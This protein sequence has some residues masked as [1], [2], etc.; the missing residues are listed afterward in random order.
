MTKLLIAV[1][2]CRRHRNEG[3]HEPIRRTWAQDI[4]NDVGFAFFMGGSS[5][6]CDND[7]IVLSVK[8]DYDALPEKSKAILNW[9]MERKYDYTVLAD[10]DTFIIPKKL[11]ALPFQQYDLAGRFGK[12]KPI[13]ET[14]RYVDGR[15]IVY[16]PCWPWPSGG[17]GYFV[18]A[19]GAK[20]IVETPYSGWAE[21]MQSGQILGPLEK[22]HLVKIGD[23]ENLECHAAW[24]FPRRRYHEEVYHPRFNWMEVMQR[25]HGENRDL[26]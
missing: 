26:C 19:K 6:I 4:P 22:Q 12:V 25:E 7:A 14:F 1:K 18:S 21:D 10:T 13:G 16:D 5:W 3:F 24:H 17:C 11:L 15:N 8:D 9:S 23:L 2:S 20:Y